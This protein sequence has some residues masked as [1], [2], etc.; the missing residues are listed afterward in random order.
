M[1]AGL[2]T[3]ERPIKVEDFKP[4][5]PHRAQPHSCPLFHKK[6]NSSR[7]PSVTAA[8]LSLAQGRG[9]WSLKPLSLT[10]MSWISDLLSDH[11]LPRV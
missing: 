6:M 3:K 1:V 8:P 10:D 5:C 7:K 4:L 9:K 2:Q 11:Q